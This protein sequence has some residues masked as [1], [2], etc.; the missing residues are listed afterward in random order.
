MPPNGR[1]LPLPP[2]SY[3][4]GIIVDGGLGMH[5][6]VALVRVPDDISQSE[7]IGTSCDPYLAAVV[8]QALRD[9]LEAAV[10][11]VD[12]VSPEAAESPISM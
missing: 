2:P 8:H 1:D 6:K 3:I 10:R 11:K 4:E 9:E 7:L 12:S 5:L